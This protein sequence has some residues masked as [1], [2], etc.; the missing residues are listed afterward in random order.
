[1]SIL[2]CVKIGLRVKSQNECVRARARTH[3]HTQRNE[4]IS[5]VLS[6]MLK[7]TT[8]VLGRCYLSVSLLRELPEKSR[9]RRGKDDAVKACVGR[10]W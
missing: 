2:N 4:T 3:A 9:D 8:S 6:C 10:A 7:E 1:M 5:Q